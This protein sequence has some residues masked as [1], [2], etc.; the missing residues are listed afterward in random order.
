MSTIEQGERGTLESGLGSQVRVVDQAAAMGRSQKGTV[1]QPRARCCPSWSCRTQPPAP[2]RLMKRAGL[3][4]SRLGPCQSLPGG[5]QHAQGRPAAAH[6]HCHGLTSAYG[7]LQRATAWCAAVPEAGRQA[8]CCRCQCCVEVGLARRQ[9]RLSPPAAE[10]SPSMWR[11]RVEMP[12]A[13]KDAYKRV[14]GARANGKHSPCKQICKCLLLR[15]M[16]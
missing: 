2:A 4:D 11:A 3:L 5:H 1:L 14:R 12:S 15:L 9:S 8:Q 6:T 13:R 16:Q 7:I 10:A